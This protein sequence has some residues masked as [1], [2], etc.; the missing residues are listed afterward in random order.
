ME[1]TEERVDRLK[2]L[3][4]EKL[5]CSWIADILGGVTRNA[6]IGKVNR[7]GLEKRR[8]APLRAPKP[9]K[10][11]LPRQL[12]R[13]VPLQ[14]DVPEEQPPPADFLGLTL[15]ELGPGQCRYPRGGYGQPFTFCGQPVKPESSF[16]P[17][18]HSI[19][20]HKI[21]RSRRAA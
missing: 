3:W 19:C 13:Y 2:S 9:I 10:P 7:L 5:S 15:M 21:D 16:C 14:C 11:R 20:C 17:Y 6:V 18:C 8:E 12:K 4:A 1:W